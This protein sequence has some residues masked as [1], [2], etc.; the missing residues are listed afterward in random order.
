MKVTNQI[1]S[2]AIGSFDGIHRGHQ[3]LISQ[4]DAVVIVERNGGYLTP[5][6]KRSLVLSQ[7]CFFYHFETIK[8]LTSREFVEKLQEDFPLLE[9]IVVGYDFAFGYQKEGDTQQLKALFSGEVVVV[10]EVKREEISI[11]SRTIKA[12]LAK[13]DVEMVQKLLGRAYRIDGEVIAG[14]GLGKKEL[15]ATLNLKVHDYD[16]PKEG[17]YA[18]RTKVGEQWF[19]SVTFLGHRVTTDGA[20][21]VETHILDEHLGEVKG[22]VWIEFVAPLR[23]NRKFDGLEALKMQIEEDIKM[24]RKLLK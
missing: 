13:G 18:T 5:G 23:E 21:A 10:D 15:V 6:Y 11:H 19:K 2:V 4:V 17:V 20:Y 14:Q 7:P 16:L 24:G 8:S 3:A 12:Y 1:K 9:T 22:K